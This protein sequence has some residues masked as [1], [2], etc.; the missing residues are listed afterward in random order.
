MTFLHR[1]VPTGHFQTVVDDKNGY[2]HVLL[3]PTSWTFLG[4]SG[5]AGI[6]PFGY[7]PL[8]ERQ[9]VHIPHF[10]FGRHKFHA[11]LGDRHAGQLM[12]TYDSHHPC[13]ARSIAHW[14]AVPCITLTRA[15]YF[16]VFKKMP[17]RSLQVCAFFAF[18][19]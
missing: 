11:Q 19:C 13:T 1:Y 10:W 12:T 7:F 5:L 9:V 16:I 15:G 3:H 17:A 8:A 4:F 18:S 14:D 6:L 2:Q